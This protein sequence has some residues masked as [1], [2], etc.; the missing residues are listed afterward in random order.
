[1]KKRILIWSASYSP[2]IGGVQNAAKE[3]AEYFKRNNWNVNVVTNRY[4]INLASN[5]IINDITLKRY[6][7]FHSP[8]N[9]IK[10]FRFDL[11]VSWL[12]FKPISIINII[13]HVFKFKPHV[14]NLHF[15]DHQLFECIVIKYLMN[16]KLIVSVHGNEVERMKELSNYSFRKL[17][18]RRLFRMAYRISGCSFNLMESLLNIFPDINKD[19]TIVVHNGVNIRFTTNKL[20]TNKS[21]YFFTAARFVPKKG[22]DILYEIKWKDFKKN[23]NLA[24]G[25]KSELKKIGLVEDNDFINVIGKLPQNE[26]LDYL[27]KSLIT[28]IPSKK[29]PYGIFVAESLCSGS[30]LIATN[31]GGIPEV[32]ELAKSNLSHDDKITFD[33]WVKI[34]E[35]DPISI[36]IAVNQILNNNS[37]LKS[38]IKVIT[39]VREQFSWDARLEKIH[40]SFN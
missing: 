21:D 15:P 3:F 37:S 30:P 17:L 34:V 38:Y 1:M 39:L 25:N 11:L 2:V 26:I 24:G 33:N 36:K 16:F 6:Y 19:K 18:Y 7:F 14:I 27:S 4:P 32:I 22:I 29:E 8:L 35:P 31:V 23:L 5:E 9:Y 12:I 10:S 13:V 28:I 40:K 20:I